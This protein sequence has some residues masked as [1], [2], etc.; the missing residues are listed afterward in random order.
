MNMQWQLIEPRNI[1]YVKGKLD[2]ATIEYLWRI[3]NKAKN[4]KLALTNHQLAG[5]INESYT[6][7]D[8]DDFFF[9][10]IILDVASRYYYDYFG[11]SYDQVNVHPVADVETKGLC[12]KD[13]WVNFQ[14]KHE[15]NPIHNHSGLFSFVI[16]LKIPFEGKDQLKLPI[17]QNSNAP[18]SSCFQFTY[19]N[20]LGQSTDEK[21]VLGKEDEGTILLFPSQL[22]HQVYPFYDCEKERVSMSGNIFLTPSPKKE[23]FSNEKTNIEDVYMCGEDSVELQSKRLESLGSRIE[24]MMMNKI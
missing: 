18:L 9:E 23:F 1:P 5:N 3:I 11:Q 2:L 15:F 7:I 16:W 12:L 19:A 10:N 24:T 22:R 20:V 6:V 14:R 21:Y 4:D 8:E 13:F 17:S